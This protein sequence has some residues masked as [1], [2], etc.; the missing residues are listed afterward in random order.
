LANVPSFFLL[1]RRTE[2]RGALG[3]GGG[4]RRQPRARRQPGSGGKEGGRPLGS[5]PP[6]ISG[7]EA[8]REGSHGG[9]QQQTTAAVVAPL[10]GST[11]ARSWGKRGREP[12][13]FHCLPW[14]RLGRSEE[15][16]SV[17]AGALEAAAMVVAVL[18]AGAEA[19]SG[20]GGR[21]GDELRG[22]PI[23]RRSKAVGKHYGR[24]VSS[25]SS[26][27]GGGSGGGAVLR[28]HRGEHGRW[29]RVA[30]RAVAG[31]VL[32]VGEVDAL[33]TCELCL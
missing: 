5:I 20:G 23:C 18:G 32:G 30:G 7:K 19:R 11:A 12:R 9:G 29:W 31:K 14:L 4:P 1:T 2:E 13:G 3:A 15:G 28:G 16:S 27:N 6:S 26:F 25:R 8:C 22:E 24:P 21:G 33:Q 10:R 17:V